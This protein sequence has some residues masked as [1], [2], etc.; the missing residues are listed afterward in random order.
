MVLPNEPHVFD[1]LDET[2]NENW[3]SSVPVLNITRPISFAAQRVDLTHGWLSAM[4]NS[5]DFHLVWLGALTVIVILKI[6]WDARVFCAAPR[7]AALAGL[8]TI[9]GAAD[10]KTDA[11]STTSKLWS[12]I[13]TFEWT[14][15]CL[16]IITVLVFLFLIVLLFRILRY[17]RRT[18]S[19]IER[20]SY[21]MMEDLSPL[22]RRRR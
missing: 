7:Y 1:T 16:A 8:F 20:N 21:Q 5:D 18:A 2:F 4:E 10:T 15:I 17:V 13:N 6:T 12:I 3:A 22:P 9:T 11:E 19:C 14:N